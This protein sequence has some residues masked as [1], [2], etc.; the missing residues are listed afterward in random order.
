[1]EVM[2]AM[3]LFPQDDSVQVD[4]TPTLD[5]SLTRGSGEPDIDTSTQLLS[6][7][8]TGQQWVSPDADM[9]RDKPAADPKADRSCGEAENEQTGGDQRLEETATSSVTSRPEAA[10]KHSVGDELLSEARNMVEAKGNGSCSAPIPG[11]SGPSSNLPEVPELYK[12]SPKQSTSSSEDPD[13]LAAVLKRELEELC[14]PCN[15]MFECTLTEEGCKLPQAKRTKGKG[16]KYGACQGVQLSFE[17]LRGDDKDSLH[18]I[19]QYM[20]NK[21]QQDKLLL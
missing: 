4:C 18:Q 17:W 11:L 12:E 14:V 1:M 20:K 9:S 2:P 3:S 15:A 16:G 7:T 21:L 6:R 13:S 5:S 8:Q 19:T 10:D